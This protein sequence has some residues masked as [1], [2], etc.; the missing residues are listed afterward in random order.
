M[1]VGCVQTVSFYIRDLSIRRIWYLR[2]ILEPIPLGTT[3][4]N[5]ILPPQVKCILPKDEDVNKVQGTILSIRVFYSWDFLKDLA[6]RNNF[7]LKKSLKPSGLRFKILHYCSKAVR[8]VRK[9]GRIGLFK[10]G[11]H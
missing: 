11:T 5:F 3:V 4:M 6:R 8:P 2:R 9:K 7:L 1:C 10:L